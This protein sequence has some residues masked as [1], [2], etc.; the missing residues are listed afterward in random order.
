MSG[1]ENFYDPEKNYLGSGR[2]QIPLGTSFDEWMEFGIRM[3]W[4]G[5]PVCSTHD[6]IPM[7]E[8]EESMWEQGGDPC[9]HIIRMYEDEQ[10]KISIEIT[11]S[12]TNWRNHYTL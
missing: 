1:N 6:G 3:G 9:I 4:C 5:P 2:N 10:Q 11:H 7:S 8:D 12:P